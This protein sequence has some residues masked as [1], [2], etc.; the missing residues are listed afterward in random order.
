M[1]RRLQQA[2]PTAEVM[3][4]GLGKDLKSCHIFHF[5]SE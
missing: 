5:G 3:G 4:N 1:D 2:Y